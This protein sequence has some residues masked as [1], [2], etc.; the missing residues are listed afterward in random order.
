ME[1]RVS[2]EQYPD[3]WEPVGLG[4][5]IIFSGYINNV[6]PRMASLEI[7][8]DNSWQNIQ[9]INERRGDLRSSLTNGS[10]EYALYIGFWGYFT[11][12]PANTERHI[13][14]SY[15]AIFEDGTK[16]IGFICKTTLP[17]LEQVREPLARKD[18]HRQ[19]GMITICLP[20]YQPKIDLFKIQLDSLVHQ[21]QEN[22]RCIVCDDASDDH[23]VSEMRI[24]CARDK[25]FQLMLHSKNVGFY[26]NFERALSYVN[27]DTDYI[28][29][30][31]Q[32]DY[33]YP[34]KLTR[35]TNAFTQGTALVYSDMRLVDGQGTTIAN[36]YWTGRKN[37]YTN[38]RVLM[39][40]NTITGA[41]CLFGKNLLDTILPFPNRVSDAYHDHWIAMV[42]FMTGPIRYIP[43]PLYDYRQ[44][45]GNVIGH[46]SFNRPNMIRSV[47]KTII[48]RIIRKFRDIRTH[49][50]SYSDPASPIKSSL[51]PN[52]TRLGRMCTW[53]T[54][55]SLMLSLL[56]KA[57]ISPMVNAFNHYRV[58]FLEVFMNQYRG[59][60]L[61]STVIRLRTGTP[62]TPHKA[63]ALASYGNSKYT[64]IRLLYYYLLDKATGHTTGNRDLYM[65]LGS[66]TYYF[67]WFGWMC[68]RQ[69]RTVSRKSAKEKIIRK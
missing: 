1:R 48:T 64:W 44:H 67:D 52:H 4:T 38:L 28:A 68:R 2:F 21:T 58:F 41:A 23:V 57:P 5:A 33:W 16:E 10:E 62:D 20:T 30:C 47:G 42:A 13:S 50:M 25:R 9:H 40:A 43:E 19:R 6:L 15:R 49:A 17:C 55:H 27:S 59:L 14:F 46:T 39:A 65:A 66:L 56:L 63:S 3:E 45:E 8:F 53:L 54:R 7:G 35:L 36:T 22:W 29:L 32:D 31:D 26:K 61:F 24:L 12:Y 51:F 37:N 69:M 11:L 60:Q 34:E 18:D